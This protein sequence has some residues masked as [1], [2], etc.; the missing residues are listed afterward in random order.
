[1]DGVQFGAAIAQVL[2]VAMTF[3]RRNVMTDRR[4][5]PCIDACIACAEECE[6]C[7]EECAQEQDAAML[8]ECI[9]LDRDCSELCRFT[10]SWLVRGGRLREEMCKVCGEVCNFC[11]EECSKHD[12]D[13]CR[14]CADA[15]RRSSEECYRMAGAV[16]S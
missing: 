1:M 7:A 13:H 3:Q 9:R 14:R 12:H 6:R 2:S 15:C 10:A 8:A 4:F 5:D 11:A 16:V